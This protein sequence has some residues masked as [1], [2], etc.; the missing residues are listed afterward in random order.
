MPER[1]VQRRPEEIGRAHREMRAGVDRVALETHRT[2]TRAAM[3]H[4]KL[5][6]HCWSKIAEIEKLSG[7]LGAI[8]DL[9][10]I[11]KTRRTLKQSEERVAADKKKEHG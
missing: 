10:G 3:H 7:Q 9:Y 8:M 2:I 5:C 11:P 4:R 1:N 6:D